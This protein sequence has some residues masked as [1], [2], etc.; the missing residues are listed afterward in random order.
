MRAG[1]DEV[2]REPSVAV[3]AIDPTG[4]GD[5]F[6]AAFV[7]GSLAGWTLPERLRFGNLCAGL[8][9]RHHGGSFSAPGWE[10]IGEWINGRPNDAADYRFLGA[11]ISGASA[12]T[13]PQ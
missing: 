13:A 7:F 4:A 11:H 10:E 6:D 12:G 8:S 1:S 2:V 9:V 3:E 5:V